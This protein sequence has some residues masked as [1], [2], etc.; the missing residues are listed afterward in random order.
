MRVASCLFLLGTVLLFQLNNLPRLD[1]FLIILVP[2]LCLS[3]FRLCRYLLYLVSGFTWSLYISQNVMQK[4]IDPDLEGIDVMVSG[5]VSSLPMN[6][7]LYTRFNL[8]VEALMDMNGIRSN[9]PGKIRLYWYKPHPQIIPGQYL[10]LTVRLKQPHGFKNPGGFDYEAWLFQEKIRATGYIRKLNHDAAAQPARFNIH[11]LR[12][13]LRNRLEFVFPGQVELYGLVPALILGDRSRITAK[14]QEMLIQTGTGHLLAI[15]GMHIGLIAGFVFLVSRWLWPLTRPHNH[16][17]PAQH[18][19]AIASIIAA[20]TYA[21]ISGFGV[22]A[23][24]AV[25]ML[26]VFLLVRLLQ[27][28]INSVDALAFAMIVVLIWNPMSVISAGFWL[29][30]SAVALILYVLQ[31]YMLKRNTSGFRFWFILQFWICLGLSPV[32]AI[33][34]NQ[35]SLWSVTANMIAIPL[36]SLITMPLLL[37]GMLSSFLLGALSEFLL[38]TAVISLDYLWKLLEILKNSGYIYHPVAS[39]SWLILSMALMAVLVILLP[40]ALR[41][42]ILAGFGFLPLFFPSVDVPEVGDFEMTVLDV[43]QGLSVVV[44]THNHLLLFD[45]G[46]GNRQAYDAG[47]SIVIPFLRHSGFKTIDMIVQSH[48]DNDHIGGLASILEQINV[49]EV[50]T[51]VPESIS[52]P[53]TRPCHKGEYWNWDG[54][55]FE[56]LHPVSGQNFKGNNASCVL[57]LGNDDLSVLLT[58]DIER[59]AELSL[60]AENTGNLQS[61]VLL[62]PHHGS[63]TSSNPAFVRAVSA[64]HVI[65]SSGY[66]NRFR[67]P[68]QDIISRYERLGAEFFN[69]AS[70]GAV[71]IK[72]TQGRFTI[73]T[74]RQRASRIWSH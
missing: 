61:S 38:H 31:S 57:K 18:V 3:E 56:F 58:G 1:F 22:P 29:S 70:D 17:L 41:Y 11:T 54:I 24:R 55:R 9:N 6:L 73:T 16:F 23:Q 71:T 10:N 47:S 36:I 40:Q 65:F 13:H 32:T 49:D 48:G 51:S 25:L 28:R 69:T 66:L 34:F 42:R 53:V 30:F 62:A 52:H 67:L 20:F 74:E 4:A 68:N 60:L 2:L 44:K 15:S 39:P 7:D 43:G 37:A 59:Q 33:W 8:D 27:L 12:Y 45:T 63:R 5:Y 19:A 35:V 26:F 72:S 14:Q 64:S 50:V 21:A 46:P